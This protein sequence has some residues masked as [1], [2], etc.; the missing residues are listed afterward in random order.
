MDATNELCFCCRLILP[1]IVD[2]GENAD[3]PKFYDKYKQVSYVLC[4]ELSVVAECFRVFDKRSQV[5]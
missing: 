5:R 2:A 3:L 4:R 1:S